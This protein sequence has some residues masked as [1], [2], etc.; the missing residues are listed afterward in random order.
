[1]EARRRPGD[2]TIV[3][4]GIDL[5]SDLLRRVERAIQEIRERPFGICADCAR[6]IPVQRLDA[7]RWSPY[8]VSC[9]ESAEAMETDGAIAAR[10]GAY[11]HAG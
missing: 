6:L 1:M 2:R 8:C 7:V 10:E 4:D 9:Q 11:A 5:G 3:T